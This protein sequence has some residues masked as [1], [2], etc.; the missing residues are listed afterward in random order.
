[1]DEQQIWHAALERLRTSIKPAAFTC[2]FQRTIALSWQEDIFIVGVPNTFARAQLEV[3]YFDQICTALSDVTGT[4]LRVQ[5]TVSPDLLLRDDQFP[6]HSDGKE[7]ESNI[8][9]FLVVI[10]KEAFCYKA[11]VPDVPGCVAVGATR[12]EAVQRVREAL[13]TYLEM[14]DND[15]APIPEPQTT[16]QYIRL[17]LTLNQEQNNSNHTLQDTLST[18]LSASRCSFCQKQQGQ[19][20]HLTTGPGGVNICNEC[21]EY[22]REM[23][24]EGTADFQQMKQALASRMQKTIS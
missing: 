11:S 9:A 2:W 8:A 18:T 17:P 15:H 5:L 3:R 6:V 24:E 1:M 10:A 23:I 20:I 22:C 7:H 12:E 16:A 21:V 13:Q 4:P 14:Q 19:D